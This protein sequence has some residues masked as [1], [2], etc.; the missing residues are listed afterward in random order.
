MAFSL[1]YR[2]TIYPDI[3]NVFMLLAELME[4]FFSS[5]YYSL[6]YPSL[7]NKSKKQDSVFNF[8]TFMRSN[9]QS[10][11]KESMIN[12]NKIREICASNRERGFKM[13]MDSFQVPIYNYIRRLVVSHED[14]EDIIQ[15]VYTRFF[16]R[17]SEKGYEDIESP[18][19]FLIN[20]AKFECRTYFSDRKK[21]DKVS[22]FSDYT[23][24]DMVAI[25]R[26]M[27]KPQQRLED[28]ISN[29]IVAK[30]IFDDIMKTDELTGQIFYLHFAC[31]MKLED[32]AK[33]LDVKLSTVKNKL[34][35]T[36]EK[37]KKKFK[38]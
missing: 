30:Q 3:R 6:P 12:E 38:L 8:H 4:T 24:E 5:Y 15:N 19:A 34:Y 20:I 14:A 21:D 29:K 11:E 1:I 23:E 33:A 22:S 7:V 13:L 36:I 16:K 9:R 37:Q 25:E 2:L 32:V 18:E 17:I 31:D 27:S 26:E 35:R 10:S 28:V